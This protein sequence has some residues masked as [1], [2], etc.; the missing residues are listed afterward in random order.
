MSL[1]FLSIPHLGPLRLATTA[2]R[3]AR[4]GS[5]GERGFQAVP[6]P[7]LGSQLEEMGEEV[8]VTCVFWGCFTHCPLGAGHVL[9]PE[10][11]LEVLKHAPHLPSRIFY[12]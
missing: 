11:R 7:L 10:A 3:Q 2:I 6:W 5:A 8:M 9:K 12:Q 1:R 4:L